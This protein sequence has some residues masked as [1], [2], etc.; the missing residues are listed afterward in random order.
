MVEAQ[1][2]SWHFPF[3]IGL[4]QNAGLPIVGAHVPIPGHALSVSSNGIVIRGTISSDI[5]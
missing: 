5:I 2:W 4:S 3:V 1:S